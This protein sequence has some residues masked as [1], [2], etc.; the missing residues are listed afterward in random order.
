[1]GIVGFESHVAMTFW[2]AF[3]LWHLN[4]TML[5]RCLLLRMPAGF[6]EWSRAIVIG[7]TTQVMSCLSTI[8]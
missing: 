8:E 5:T 4:M 6:I 1:M 2:N 3:L 7:L